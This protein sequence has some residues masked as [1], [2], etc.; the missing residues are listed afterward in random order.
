[1]A[2]KSTKAEIELRV[3]AVRQLVLNGASHYDIVRFGSENWH[4]TSRQT[5]DY[6]AEARKSIKE[7]ADA[8]RDM[9]FAEHVEHRRALR[10]KANNNKQYKLELE[11]AK[12]EAKL[13][14]LYPAERHEMTGK[15]GGAI[16]IDMHSLTDE[17]LAALIR[18]GM[19]NASDSQN[20]TE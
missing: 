8:Y 19:I 4:I 5:E 16:S 7:A 18:A 9:A 20:T 17:Q 13:L 10:R 11:I 12:D 15:D 14:N 6:L 3:A 1:M 2:G